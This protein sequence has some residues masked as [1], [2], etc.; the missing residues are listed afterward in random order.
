M[1]SFRRFQVV[2][3]A[4]VCLWFTG[5]RVGWADPAH[6]DFYVEDPYAPHVTNGSTA[7]LGTA[8]GFIYDQPTQIIALGLTAA[9]GYRFGRLAIESELDWLDFQ[10]PGSVWTPLGPEQSNISVGNGERL[11]ALARYDAL[12]LGSNVVGPN[13]MFAAY[14]EGGGALAWNHWD[15]PG[16]LD[17]DERVVPD[18]TRRPEGILGFGITLDHRLQEPI[19]FPHRVAWF[20]GWRLEMAAHEPMTGVSCRGTT[21]R[22]VTM[23]DSGGY[24][25]KSM[26]FQSSLE[27]TF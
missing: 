11:L 26:L 24:I 5:S 21:C 27:F 1:R 8:V 9:A 14:V 19:G 13:S 12:R 3:L 25:D 7:R 16:A 17:I 10:T 20:L 23:S 18:A 4:S 15:R 6:P 2:V 22:P